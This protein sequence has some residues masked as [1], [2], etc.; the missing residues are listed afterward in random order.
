MIYICINIVINIETKLNTI[1]IFEILFISYLYTE[2]KNMKCFIKYSI[3]SKTDEL[4]YH[5][6]FN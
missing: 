5:Y 4:C 3:F 1:I 2:Y 6:Y